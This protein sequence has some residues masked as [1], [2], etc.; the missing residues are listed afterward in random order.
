LPICNLRFVLKPEANSAFSNRHSEIK[1]R[2]FPHKSFVAHLRLPICKLRL[3]LKPGPIATSRRSRIEIISGFRLLRPNGSKGLRPG[4]HT[5]RNFNSLNIFFSANLFG[6]SRIP[7]FHSV[8]G[9]KSGAANPLR[10]VYSGLVEQGEKIHEGARLGKRYPT[11]HQKG[12][13]GF[14]SGLLSVKAQVFVEDLGQSTIRFR[15][16]QIT[17][18]PSQPF[19]RIGGVTVLRRHKS[20]SLLEAQ[21]LESSRPCGYR[22]RCRRGWPRQ[23][24]RGRECRKD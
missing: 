24:Q 12:L 4:H 23:H 16:S 3:V 6:R 17:S 14:L 15:A 18:R 13:D 10:Y 5:F 20:F 2:H 9:E 8:P 19:L 22:L 1:N 7:T 11:L 21:A